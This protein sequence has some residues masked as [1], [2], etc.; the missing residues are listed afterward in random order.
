MLNNIGDIA[1]TLFEPSHHFECFRK[2]II[3]EHTDNNY[4]NIIEVTAARKKLKNTL[5]IKY[6]IISKNINQ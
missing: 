6:L 2:I 4:Y 1:I 5:Y 3:I